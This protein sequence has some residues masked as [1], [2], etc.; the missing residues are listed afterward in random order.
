MLFR[1]DD[2]AAPKE[3]QVG[4]HGDITQVSFSPDD[5]RFVSGCFG[6]IEI[7]DASW[8]TEE[9]KASFEER[10]KI[11]SI[12]LSPGGKF[13]AS[14]SRDGSIRLWNLDAGELVKKLKLSLDVRSVAFS[15][16]N[17]QLIA[18]GSDSRAV[19]CGTS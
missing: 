15:P 2:T 13:I 19:K 18:F 14:G 10:G 17:E 6:L 4:G 16:V 11:E 1:S 12:S 7:W 3:F 8:R 5:N 9:T